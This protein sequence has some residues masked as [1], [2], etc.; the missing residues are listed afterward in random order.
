M[1]LV[2]PQFTFD[3]TD[4]GPGKAVVLSGNDWSCRATEFE[5]GFASLP[6]NVYVSGTMVIGIDHHPESAEPQ[7]VGIEGMVT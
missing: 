1:R 4:V 2:L 3:A 6:D 7:H 5:H